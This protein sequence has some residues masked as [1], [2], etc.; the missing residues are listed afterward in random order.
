MRLG[1]GVLLAAASAS[2]IVAVESSVASLSLS[3]WSLRPI[4]D[5]SFVRLLLLQS[6]PVS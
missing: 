5:E 4:C 3:P 1:S 2:T 6:E